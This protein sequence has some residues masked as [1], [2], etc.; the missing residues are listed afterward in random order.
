MVLSKEITNHLLVRVVVSAVGD[1]VQRAVAVDVARLGVN[2]LGG[3][4]KGGE[5]KCS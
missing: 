3:Y 5:E 2:H 4:E 1:A